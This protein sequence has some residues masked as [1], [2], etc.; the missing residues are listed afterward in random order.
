LVQCVNEDLQDACDILE[1]RLRAGEYDPVALEISKELLGISDAE[2][3]IDLNASGCAWL[4]SSAIP[5]AKLGKVAKI[6]KWT[7]EAASLAEAAPRI[8]D[9]GLVHSFDKHAEQWF[10]RPVTKGDKMGEWKA[11]IERAAGSS[12]VL[13]WSTGPTLTNA[14]LARVDG[15]WFVAQF[16]RSNGELITAFVPNNSQLNAM[17]TLLGK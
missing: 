6:L 8:T 7:D 4:A 15:K 13:P 5:F 11:L 2:D 14:H 16:D 10:G 12:K 3:C 1:M 9:K 17:L